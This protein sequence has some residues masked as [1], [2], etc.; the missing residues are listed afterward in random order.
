MKFQCLILLAC[1]TVELAAKKRT[2]EHKPRAR[3]SQFNGHG[4]DVAFPCKYYF[5]KR[6]MCGKWQIT[7]TPGL[8]WLQNN[9]YLDKLWIG[10]NNTETSQGWEGRLTNKLVVKF[11]NSDQ[12]TNL[13]NKKGGQL[14]ASD[15][16][17]TGKE[18]K[19]TAFIKAKDDTFKMTFTAWDPSNRGKFPHPSFKFECYD[20]DVQLNDYPTQ[21]CGGLNYSR[22]VKR[23]AENAPYDIPERHSAMVI[24]HDVLMSDVVQTDPECIEAANI[25]QNLCTD[26]TQRKMALKNCMDILLRPRHTECVTLFQ[27]SPMQA[28]NNCMKWGCT[29]KGFDKKEKELCYNVGEAIDLCGNITGFGN[30]SDRMRTANCF[31]EYLS[32]EYNSTAAVNATA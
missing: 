20:A 17:E 29:G 8:L 19:V 5:L 24:Y 7:L 28:F 26:F 30:I 16:F 3:I 25:T 18:K 22:S 4:N 31:K 11:Y 32:I 13:V 9:Y 15:I 1:A 12:S 6:Q 2:C 10:I 27:C 14:D 21:V 23:I